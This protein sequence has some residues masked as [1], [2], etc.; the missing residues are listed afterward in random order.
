M[1]PAKSAAVASTACPLLHHGGEEGLG[2]LQVRTAD[3]DLL[4][5]GLIQRQARCE[6]ARHRQFS[7]RTAGLGASGGNS[8]LTVGPRFG[9]LEQAVL[10]RRSISS[11]SLN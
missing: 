2:A 1:R 4:V 8:S 10:A 5:D 3:G 9:V 6:L 7:A 11:R